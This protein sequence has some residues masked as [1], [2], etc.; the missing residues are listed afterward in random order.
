[1]RLILL[2]FKLL[3]L[4]VFCQLH[5]ITS[6]TRTWLIGLVE[7]KFKIVSWS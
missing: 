1:M 6:N 7:L 5:C 2:L 3:L 4:F